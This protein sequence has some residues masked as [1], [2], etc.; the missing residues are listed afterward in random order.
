MIDRGSGETQTTL[1]GLLDTSVVIVLP[2]LESDDLPQFP[3]ISTITLVEL[4]VGPLVATTA[5]ERSARQAVLQQTE[6]DFDPIPFDAGAARAF[7][8]VAASLGQAGRRSKARSF[9]AMIAAVALANGLPLY[10]ANQDDF[11]GI[12][13]LT[14]HA[15]AAR[16]AK[17]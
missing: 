9:D 8:Q 13:G 11:V 17:G 16:E 12:V 2:R 6:A 1:R 7:G 3:Q 10:T 15:V 5:L 14:V 4:S